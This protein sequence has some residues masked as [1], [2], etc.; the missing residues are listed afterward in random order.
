MSNR[1]VTGSSLYKSH[2][3]CSYITRDV[4]DGVKGVRP[5]PTSVE[6]LLKVEVGK[7]SD[8]SFAC[9]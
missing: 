3:M 7:V 4:V 9:T 1:I 8:V 5:L 2:K 6:L